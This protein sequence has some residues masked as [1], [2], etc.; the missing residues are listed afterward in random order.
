MVQITPFLP[1]IQAQCTKV[2]RVYNHFQ[3]KLYLFIHLLIYYILI[4]C[5]VANCKQPLSSNLCLF[6]HM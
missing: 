5:L 4:A 3:C 2:V 1:V 6:T